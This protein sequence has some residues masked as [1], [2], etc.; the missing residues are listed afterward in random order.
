MGLLPMPAQGQDL[1]AVYR[2]V[3]GY[4]EWAPV[5]GR[6]TPFYD[7]PGELSGQWGR[8]YIGQYI[9][10][11]GLFPLVHMSFMGEGVTLTSP[12]DIGKPTLADAAW[13]RAYIQA[14]VDIA[15][16]LKPK[17]LSLGNEVN[18]WYESHGDKQGDPDAFSEYVSLYG[19]TYDAVKAVSPDTDVFCTFAR[20]IVSENR[21]ADLTVLSMFD[22]DKMDVLVFTSY[23]FA[24]R[25][26]N[27]P[28]DIP[29]DYYAGAAAYMPGKPFGFS[30]LGWPS[31]D[32]FGGEEG[33]AD[34]LRQA[35][36][37]LTVEQ[38]IDLDLLGWAW[39]HDMDE[40]DH[41]GLIHMDGTEK[42]AYGVWKELSGPGGR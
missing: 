21:E 31:I 7:L 41:T 18:R 22:P 36:G 8:V 3:S 23:P 20:E 5:W 34:F 32:A 4:A 2:Q 40:N 35:A 12:P 6:P 1:D 26:I 16:A 14:A 19:A 15:G 25:E 39:L 9:G 10:G 27:R 37:R 13:R 42:E 33:Q 11:N 28:S 17:Y 29:D 38:G 24:V 30:E